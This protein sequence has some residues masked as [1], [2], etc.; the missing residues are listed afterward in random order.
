MFVKKRT[1]LKA[2]AENE[3]LRKILN[4]IIVDVVQEFIKRN[5][6]P[7]RRNDCRNKRALRKILR[8]Y[9]LIHP[10]ADRN[11]YVDIDELI[12]KANDGDFD[13]G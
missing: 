7:G 8:D 9:A 1:Y 12:K 5:F 3:A 10:S 4:R 11:R 13:W 6:I 2:K